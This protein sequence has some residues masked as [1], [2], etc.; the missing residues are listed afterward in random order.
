MMPIVA[1][2]SMMRL[3]ITVTLRAD[4]PVDASGNQAAEDRDDVEDDAVDAD[5]DRRP[6]EHAGREGAAKDQ[7][8]VD[9]ILIDHAGDQEASGYC[10]ASSARRAYCAIP[11]RPKRTAKPKGSPLRHPV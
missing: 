11:L 3:M 9:A 10:G 2:N 7:Q 5:L 4:A 6:A 8:A 1:S